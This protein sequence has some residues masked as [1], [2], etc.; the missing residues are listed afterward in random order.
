[1][2]VKILEKIPK[3]D[4]IQRRWLNKQIFKNKL[5]SEFVSLGRGTFNF[6]NSQN[7]ISKSGSIT[8]S[9]CTIKILSKG[10]FYESCTISGWAFILGETPCHLLKLCKKWV[11]NTFES[12]FFPFYTHLISGSV[13]WVKKDQSRFRWYICSNLHT[14]PE[15]CHM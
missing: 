15:S 12:I 4:D 9:N 3:K 1:M 8:P 6:F 7:F 10:Y 11:W 5:H 2:Y 14:A 13:L